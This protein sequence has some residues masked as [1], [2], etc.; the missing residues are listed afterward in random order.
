L[1]NQFFETKLYLI[2]TLPKHS[3][4]ILKKIG[5]KYFIMSEYRHYDALNLLFKK[6]ILS[7]KQQLIRNISSSQDKKITISS[8]LSTQYGH[9]VLIATSQPILVFLK[10]SN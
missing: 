9:F 3:L 5:Y 2:F 8:V 7:K 6:I 10:I 4:V 1:V